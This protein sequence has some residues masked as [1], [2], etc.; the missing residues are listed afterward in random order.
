MKNSLLFILI[1]WNFIVHPVQGFIDADDTTF[2]PGT[3]IR[4]YAKQEHRSD[5]V[6]T[7]GYSSWSESLTYDP[8]S[9]ANIRVN[10]GN[11]VVEYGAQQDLVLLRSQVGNHAQ[12]VRLYDQRSS[13]YDDYSAPGVLTNVLVTLA[14]DSF[15]P[16]FGSSVW[17][18]MAHAATSA[19]LS[20][21]VLTQRINPTDLMI[22][23][24]SA[25]V[26]HK[27][28]SSLPYLEK[29]SNAKI[30]TFGQQVAYH[31]TRAMVPSVVNV[32]YGRDV[33]WD[34]AIK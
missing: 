3:T 34:D 5:L 16:G 19:A 7:K 10:R 30:R 9:L 4:K 18:A 6:W 21:V 1:F 29:A 22:A 25:G 20:Q 33:S 14:V 11:V 12:F 8:L 2:R 15:L 13:Y 32:A 28:T 31:M 24:S 17:A 27:L 26:L 23:A